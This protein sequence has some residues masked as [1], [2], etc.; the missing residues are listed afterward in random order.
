MADT[1]RVLIVPGDRL[2]RLAVAEWE[3][4][5]KKPNPVYMERVDEPFTVETNEGRVSGQPG[6]YVAHDPISGHFWPVAASYREQHYEP[7][8]EAPDGA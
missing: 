3:P 5:V 2:S 1:Y 8:E 7:A 4:M 6:D